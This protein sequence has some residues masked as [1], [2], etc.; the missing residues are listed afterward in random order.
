MAARKV[1]QLPQTATSPEYVIPVSSEE[2]KHEIV[3][4]IANAM[5][6]QQ[7]EKIHIDGFRIEFEAGWGLVRASNTS[8]AITLRF[9]ANDADLLGKLQTL[10]KAG[11]NK[12][13]ETLAIPF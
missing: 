10:F 12:A 4:F 8:Q 9:E 1:A 6:A 5:E 13:D 7:G 3:S 11:L 2:K